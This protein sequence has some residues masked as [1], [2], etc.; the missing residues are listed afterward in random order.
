MDLFFTEFKEACL[1][2]DINLLTDTIKVIAIDTDDYTVDAG[3]SYSDI[4][5]ATGA[6]VA[7]ATLATKTI[8]NGVFDSANPTLPSVTG[9]E[10]EAI[11]LYDVTAGKLMAYFD[12]YTVTPSGN[13][14]DVNV[15]AGGWFTL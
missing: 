4:Q 3:H 7:E 6:E 11:V 12:G 14:L 5:A 1:N 9:D 10:F 8:A 2:G 15:D 13:N